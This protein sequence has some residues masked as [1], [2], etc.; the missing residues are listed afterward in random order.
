MWPSTSCGTCLGS[1]FG[2]WPATAVISPK[3][4]DASPSSRRIRR[5]AA[6][7]SL[8]IRRRRPFA[9]G[10]GL[11]RLRPNKRR[12]LALDAQEGLPRRR[13][14]AASLLH[15]HE[16][17]RARLDGSLERNGDMGAT[18]EDAGPPGWA[19]GTDPGLVGPA[20]RSLREL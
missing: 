4:N 2:I 14:D 1:Q 20:A 16:D 6:R 9:A 15:R 3:L 17:A 10:T 5:R 18:V 12:I 7:R 8:R 13:V 19:A 11:L